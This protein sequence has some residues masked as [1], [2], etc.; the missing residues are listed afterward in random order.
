MAN[1]KPSRGAR[2]AQSVSKRAARAPQRVAPSGADLRRARQARTVAV[3]LSVTIVAWVA[4][5]WI[6]GR[7]GW[8]VRFAFLLDFAA[9]AAFVW[10]LIVSYGVWRETRKE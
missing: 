3:V 2:G 8:P 9:L 10:A 7:L 4:A 6:G 1:R 5:Q